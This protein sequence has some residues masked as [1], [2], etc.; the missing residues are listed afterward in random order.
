MASVTR[1]LTGKLKLVVNEHKGR[2][3]KTN[4][5][6]FFG[7]TFRGKKLPW[8]D[9]AYEDFR[10]VLRKLPGRSWSIPMDYR[11][12]KLAQYVR[13]GM[14]YFG[15]SDY[16]RPIPRTRPVDS[17]PG[18]GVLLATVAQGAHQGM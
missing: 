2:L 16:Y 14:G 1:F 15:I 8:S 17:P 18:A 12:K 3:V 10:H 5:C 4:D 9:Q 6:N 13:G 11:L 7:F